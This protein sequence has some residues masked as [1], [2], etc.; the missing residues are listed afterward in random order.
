[1]LEANERR[2]KTA[3][4]R[5]AAQV[6]WERENSGRGDPRVFEQ[7]VAPGLVCLSARAI[8]LATGL[9]VGY[10]AGIKRRERVPHRRW[11]QALER[12]GG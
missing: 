3:K 1:M 10:C 7:Q 4:A 12:L 9:S 2:G 8:A 11:W 6:A 5:R